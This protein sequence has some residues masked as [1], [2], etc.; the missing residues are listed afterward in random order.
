[1]PLLSGGRLVGRVDSAREGQTLVARQISLTGAK[2]VPTAAKA[3]RKAAEWVGCMYVR[4]ERV[5]PETLAAPLA[6][7]LA[8]A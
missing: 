8:S 7:A 4:A 5:L 3:L 2:H 6:A 1:M